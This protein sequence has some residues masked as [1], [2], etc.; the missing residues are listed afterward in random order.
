MRARC[1]NPKDRAYPGYGGRGIVV[2]D[3]WRWS[4]LAF[5]ADMG[6]RPSGTTLDRIDGSGNYEPGNCR[7]ASVAEQTEN[8]PTFDAVAHA[9]TIR[10]LA[11]VWHA[12]EDGRVW[13]SEH[14]RASWQ[15]RGFRI[16]RCERCGTE[17]RTRDAA[18]HSRFCSNACKTAARVASGVDDEQREC[19]ACG[20]T[21]TVNKYSRKRSCNRSCAQRL[22]RGQG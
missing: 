20:A 9:A 18:G 3:R 11:A 14:G 8:R 1:H 17:Y 16:E 7:W 2:C 10:P 19:A 13:H 21:F 12:S 4:F 5:L 15:G 22:R 6:E